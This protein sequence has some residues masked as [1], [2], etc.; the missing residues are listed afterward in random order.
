MRMQPD[1]AAKVVLVTTCAI[2]LAVVI[3]KAGD[4]FGT[5]VVQYV[6]GFVTGLFGG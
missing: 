4:V 1:S 6:A 5:P 2:V 3:V